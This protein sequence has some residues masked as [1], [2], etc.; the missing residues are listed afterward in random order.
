MTEPLFDN[1]EDHAI[2]EPFTSKRRLP[3]RSAR[4]EARLAQADRLR[5][6]TAEGYTVVVGKCGMTVFRSF[7][8]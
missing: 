5:V 4:T 6:L 7:G 1:A 8:W 2:D 3:V